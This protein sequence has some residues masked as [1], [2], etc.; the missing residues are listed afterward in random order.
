MSNFEGTP[1]LVIALPVPRCVHGENYRGLVPTIMMMRTRRHLLKFNNSP[2]PPPPLSSSLELKIASICHFVTP[3]HTTP[4]R[5]ETHTCSRVQHD[6][7]REHGGYDCP[8]ISNLIS[9]NALQ[10]GA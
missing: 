9:L 2:P 5:T 10:T 6:R 3:N 7:V 8:Q 4:H 1:D